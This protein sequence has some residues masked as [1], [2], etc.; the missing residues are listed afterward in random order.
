MLQTHRPF[1]DYQVGVTEDSAYSKIITVLTK[2]EAELVPEDYRADFV[3]SGEVT[4]SNGKKQQSFITKIKG[5]KIN[6]DTLVE[7]S[8]EVQALPNYFGIAS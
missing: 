2:Q 1:P 8:P 6:D 3:K 4:V 7:F 5:I